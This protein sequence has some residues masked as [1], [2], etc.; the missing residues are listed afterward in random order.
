MSSQ[1]DIYRK[2]IIDLRARISRERDRKRDDN[3]RFAGYIRSV[4]DASSK[5]SYRRQK[6]DAASS[7]DR[8]IAGW[9]REIA[10]LQDRIRRL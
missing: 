5:A 10:V 1:K 4:R 8:N 9:Q 7:H 6:I 2:Q 3:A